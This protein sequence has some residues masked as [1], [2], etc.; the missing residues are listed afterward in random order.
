MG[1]FG[2]RFYAETNMANRYAEEIAV[3]ESAVE[4]AFTT[5]PELLARTLGL[6]HELSVI[7]RQAPLPSGRLDLLMIG[8]NNLFLIELKVESFRRNHLEQIGG[9]KDDL[10]V[11]QSRG[12]IP[13]GPVLSHL[14][15]TSG[16]E[17]DVRLCDERSVGLVVYSPGDILKDFF[18]RLSHIAEFATIRP[19]D[20]GVWNIHLINRAMYGLLETN[21]IEELAK[22]IGLATNSVT[23]HLRLAE[24]LG[25]VRRLRRL[26][27]LTDAGHEYVLARDTNSPLGALSEEQTE[28]LR[29]IVLKDPFM[30]PTTFGIHC[31]VEVIF[32]LARNSYPVSVDD[33]IRTYREFVG[34]RHDWTTDRSAL[35]GARSFM[36]FSIELGLIGKAGANLY[37]TPAG[38]RFVTMLQLHKG[39]KLV[40]AFH[41]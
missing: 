30:S 34:K 6:T 20:Y 2:V 41:G 1:R 28:I 15:V 14:L 37:L 31:L 10:L 38:F 33:L 8:R 21:S 12:E 3:R 13:S 22:A 11:M 5:Y 32:T 26:Y 29:R 40:D 19:R 17:E 27:Y 23:N 25:L 7:L 4:D 35:L 16:S 18:A 39:I 36:N 24:Q 9:Y